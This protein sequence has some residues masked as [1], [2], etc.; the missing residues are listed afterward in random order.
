MHEM[1]K[2]DVGVSLLTIL[3]MS[4]AAALVVLGEDRPDAYLAISILI[5]FIYTSIDPEIRRYSSLLPLDIALATIFIII[6]AI[7]VLKV[8]GAI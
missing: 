4:F 8:L 6:A 3:I 7:R 2:T 1:P 5:Y